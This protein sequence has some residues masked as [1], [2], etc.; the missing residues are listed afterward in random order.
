LIQA[1]DRGGK[2]RNFEKFEK[3]D[4]QYNGNYIPVLD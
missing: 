3:K 1:G 4:D 2:K